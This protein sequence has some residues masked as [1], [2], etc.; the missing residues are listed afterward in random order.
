VVAIRGD[1]QVRPQCCGGPP[2][3][4]ADQVLAA[5]A[6]RQWRT[7]RWRHGTK[8]WLRKKC[9]AIRAWRMTADS[10]AHIGCLVGERAARGQPEEHKFSWSNLSASATLEELVA[11]AHRRHAI[12]QC[13]EEAKEELG[14]DQYQGRGLGHMTGDICGKKFLPTL[15][16]AFKAQKS[17]TTPQDRA[18]KAVPVTWLY[19]GGPC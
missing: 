6:R 17:S 13:H 19:A 16:R 2:S 5:I 9:V 8:G 15:Q 11:Y 12:E 10:E 3:Q 14:W 18:R 4:R 7:I 1:F